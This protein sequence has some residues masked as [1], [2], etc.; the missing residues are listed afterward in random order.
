MRGMFFS[1][2]KIQA[3]FGDESQSPKIMPLGAA[4][5]KPRLK[6]SAARRASHSGRSL[7]IAP[8]APRARPSATADNI[9][10]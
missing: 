6:T 3:P 8:I 2:Q 10:S 7:V 5:C 4:A 1:V 9:C